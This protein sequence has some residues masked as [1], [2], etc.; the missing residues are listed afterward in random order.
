MY[1]LD[2][3]NW[4]VGGDKLWYKEDKKKVSGK[5]KKRSKIM[6]KV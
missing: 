1:N 4:C 3:Y 2:D 5:K 6:R